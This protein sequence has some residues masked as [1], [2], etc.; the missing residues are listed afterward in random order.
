MAKE[1]RE[2]RVQS[3]NNPRLLARRF[4]CEGSDLVGAFPTEPKKTEAGLSLSYITRD[5]RNHP[6][7]DMSEGFNGCAHFSKGMCAIGGGECPVASVV[8]VADFH[9][10]IEE[11]KKLKY[12]G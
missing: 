9:K 2:A 5:S 12:I 8:S 1:I 3:K 6:I 4:H 7:E 11:L 10:R